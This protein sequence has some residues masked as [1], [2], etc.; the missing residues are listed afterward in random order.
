VTE[1]GGSGT[2]T[3]SHTYTTTGIYEATL[4][5]TE[6]GGGQTTKGYQYV[7]VYDPQPSTHFGGARI[8]TAPA[9]SYPQNTSL[10]GDVFFG[11]TARYSGANAVG[12]VSMEFKAANLRFQSTSITSLVT[13]TNKATLR[14]TGTINGSGSY[15]FLVTGIDGSG[16]N[17]KIRFQIKQGT[18][19]IF[20]SQIGA[21]DIT[22]PT[23]SVTGTVLVN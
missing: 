8:F 15:D 22:D 7:A 1:S 16:G 17:G 3:G 12:N 5:V 18:T 23:A 10:T 9:G 4:T 19:T 11:V 21:T 20:D 13:T 14:G 2:V 6:N